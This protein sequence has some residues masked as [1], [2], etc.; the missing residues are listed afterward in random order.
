[1]PAEVVEGRGGHRLVDGLVPVI[2]L[3]FHLM[4]IHV[5]I[6]SCHFYT[7]SVLP[8]RALFGVNVTEKP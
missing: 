6:V 3:C 5:W 7:I 4:K 2:A 1:M 8:E